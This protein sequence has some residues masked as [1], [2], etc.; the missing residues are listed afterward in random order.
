MSASPVTTSKNELGGIQQI[1]VTHQCVTASGE[2]LQAIGLARPHASGLPAQLEVRF[3]PA[4]MA[5][6]PAVWG[7]YWVLDLDAD[8]QLA[9]VGDPS[10]KYL[11]I[12]SRSPTVSAAAYDALLLKLSAMGFD[13]G[14]LE[15][16]KQP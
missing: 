4:W 7:N 16:T 3:A 13:I 8:Y 14:Q 5:W 12:L 15:K 2:K 9:A 1:E 6:L 11:W 10:L